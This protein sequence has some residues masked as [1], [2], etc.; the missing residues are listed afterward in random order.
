MTLSAAQVDA[1]FR[2]IDL[3]AAR[4]RDA[5]SDVEVFGGE[6]FL[7]GSRRVLDHLLRRVAERGIRAS[8]QTNGYFLAQSLDFFFEHQGEIAQV[9]VTLDGP[10]AVHDRRR[11]PKSGRPTFDR[12]VV[13]ICRLLDTGLPI[14]LNVRMNV[15]REKASDLEAMVHVYEE[16]GWCKDE[17]VTFVAAPV[18]NRC[19]NLRCTANLLRWDETFERVFPLSTDTGGGP[20]DVSV[21]KIVSYVRHYLQSV[22]RCEQPRFVPKV[23]Y[24]EAAASRLYAFHPDGRIYPCPE[25]VSIERLA[26][27]TYYPQVHI[28]RRRVSMWRKQTILQRPRCRDCTIATFCGGGCVLTALMHNGTMAQP[29]CEN[30]REILEAYLDHFRCESE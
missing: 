2:L 11:V 12:I 18:D 15:D 10:R 23:I 3:H 22:A 21:F 29:E 6:P 5:S 9:Q 28:D 26:I 25:T 13:G 24:C 4:H 16:N 19:G 8:I 7:P 1:A 14:R 30:A 17:R 27:G 20:F